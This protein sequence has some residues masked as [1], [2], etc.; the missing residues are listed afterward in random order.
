MAPK[1]VTTRA[2]SSL[3]KA[4][5]ATLAAK[6][7]KVTFADNTLPLTTVN[8]GSDVENSKQRPTYTR[9]R[10]SHLQS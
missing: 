1:K 4:T 7:G 8:N 3:Y 2:N 10:H 5:K 9:G 6:K